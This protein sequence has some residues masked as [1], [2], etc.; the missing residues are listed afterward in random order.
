MKRKRR[1]RLARLSSGLYRR[2]TAAKNAHIDSSIT[3]TPRLVWGGFCR[4]PLDRINPDGNLEA[5]RHT[6]MHNVCRFCLSAISHPDAVACLTRAGVV[7]FAFLTLSESVTEMNLIKL[8]NTM[9][10]DDAV[11]IA[12]IQDCYI[13]PYLYTRYRSI[14]PNPITEE[15]ASKVASQPD[16][17]QARPATAKQPTQPTARTKGFL[18]TFKSW[19]NVKD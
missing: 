19:D 1:T 8:A 11:Y 15:K 14:P 5:I 7:D 18:E 17:D 3:G 12:G 13:D 4:L 9:G 10:A 2:R 6:D 16:E